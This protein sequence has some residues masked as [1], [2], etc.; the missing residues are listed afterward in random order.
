MEDAE[1]LLTG[2]GRE[3]FQSLYEALE[4][5]YAKFADANDRIQIAF[6]NYPDCRRMVAVDARIF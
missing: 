5:L 4:Q 1:N 6:Q 2:F 3:L